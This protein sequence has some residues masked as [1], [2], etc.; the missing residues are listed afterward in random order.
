MIHHIG[1]IY[2]AFIQQN[3]NDPNDAI[4]SPDTGVRYQL[5]TLLLYFQ[6]EDHLSEQYHLEI[7]L[8]KQN[9]QKIYQENTKLT[10]NLQ[11]HVEFSS[12]ITTISNTFI[13]LPTD[14]IKIWF[15]HALHAIGD[16]T[17]VE[18]ISVLLAVNENQS[19][20]QF[21][22]WTE[23]KIRDMAISTEKNAIQSFHLW[24]KQLNQDKTITVSTFD[25]A[26]SM[27]ES[28][29]LKQNDINTLL[30]VPITYN[31][32]F[33]GMLRFIAI[34]QPIDWA[35]DQI[36]QIKLTG[37]IFI[38]ALKRK[39]IEDELQKQQKNLEQEIVERRRTE[40]S[41]YEKN[42]ELENA[43]KDLKQAQATVVQQEKMVAIGQLA[44]GV[45]HEINN[46]TGFVI[47]NFGSLN[48]YL[49]KIKDFFKDQDK[50]I[51]TLEPGPQS[52]EIFIHKFNDLGKK[53]KLDFILED[54]SAI[55]KDSNEGLQRIRLIVQDLSNFSR[56]P[57][58]DSTI[59]DINDGLRST[60]NIAWNELKRKAEIIQELNELPPVKINIQEINQVILNILINAAQA[61]EKKGII[62]IKSWAKDQY[63]IISLADNGPGINEE[64]IKRIFEP[65]YTTKAVGKG[66]GLGLAI[67]YEIMKKHHGEIQVNSQLG[68]GTTFILKFPI[69]AQ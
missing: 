23:K 50:M 67:S 44:A 68:V 20:F 17:K 4:D 69:Q 49:T 61:I 22:E 13:N 31:D 48:R 40:N 46:P 1:Q 43:Y 14:E 52:F 57:M 19:E 36:A 41:L 42:E 7:D 63:V 18:H 6:E 47:S 21:F 28:D 51:K 15:H 5:D 16:F 30:L 12:I 32:V 26:I 59:C 34:N 37:E 58:N 3:L 27:E 8:L 60:I 25:E 45:A 65:F 66:T 33:Y 11:D 9:N 62:T 64:N 2:A 24:Q 56:T 54:L 35:N 29:F 38:N 10:Q 39:K 53:Y 55:I